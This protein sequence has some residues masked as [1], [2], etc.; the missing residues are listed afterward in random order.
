MY[1]RVISVGCQ[2]RE[3]AF[4]VDLLAHAGS[5][6]LI[7]LMDFA[8]QRYPST[9]TTRAPF[10]V[11]SPSVPLAT[12]RNGLDGGHLGECAETSVASI[13]IFGIFPPNSTGPGKGPPSR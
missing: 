2:Q 3:G 10:S 13:V 11:A 7:V 9:L 6:G 5:P 4:P 12:F 1:R 8:L